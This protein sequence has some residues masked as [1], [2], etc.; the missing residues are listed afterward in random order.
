MTEARAMKPTPRALSWSVLLAAALLL[1]PHAR[2]GGKKTDALIGK[3]TRAYAGL[4]YERAVKTLY[5]ALKLPGN[6]RSQLVRIYQL[7]GLSLASLKKGEAAKQVFARLLALEP[8]FRLG[9]NIAP[10]IRKPF[11]ELLRKNPRPVEVDIARPRSARGGMPL[12]LPVQVV[13]DQVGMVH[14]IRVFF[15]RA[16]LKWSSVRA[17][18]RGEGKHRINIPAISWERGQGWTGPVS[19]YAIVEDEYKSRLKIFGDPENPFTIQVTTGDAPPVAAGADDDA[20]YEQWWVWVLIGGAVAGAT[21][22]TVLLTAGD[23]GSG[24]VLFDVSFRRQ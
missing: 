21:T 1:A 23:E 14:S 8:S 3:A 2:A 18:L 7:W 16:N 19:W 24:P 6:S 4:E 5:Q 22:A 11:E 10:H 9:E 20:W 17:R 12:T 15:K 13:S